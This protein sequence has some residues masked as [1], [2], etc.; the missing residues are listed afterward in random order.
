MTHVVKRHHL[1]VPRST[2]RTL[3]MHGLKS[4]TRESLCTGG[5]F[6]LSRFL[7]AQ[8]KSRMRSCGVTMALSYVFLYEPPTS[9]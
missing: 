5:D 4:R 8:R 7:A 2:T 6:V 9:L 3:A 1:L